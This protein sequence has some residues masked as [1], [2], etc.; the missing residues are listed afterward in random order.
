[1]ARVVARRLRDDGGDDGSGR[2]HARFHGGAVA[3]GSSC[4]QCAEWILYFG[5]SGTFLMQDP[6][7]IARAACRYT[8]TVTKHISTCMI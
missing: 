5:R 3:T 1:M 2:P 7:P 6:E 4:D 8:V